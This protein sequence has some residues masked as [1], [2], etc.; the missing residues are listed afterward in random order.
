M[1]I[2]INKKRDNHEFDYIMVT[3]TCCWQTCD[4]RAGKCDFFSPDEE[5]KPIGRF[6]NKI[7]AF[8]C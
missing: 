8:N 2:K 5:K 4:E 6:I 3:G 7:K 1:V